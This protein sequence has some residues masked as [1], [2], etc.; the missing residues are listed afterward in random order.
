L[1]RRQ[2]SESPDTLMRAPSIRDVPLEWDV[3][4]LDELEHRRVVATPQRQLVSQAARALRV[5]RQDKDG[6]SQFA[7][8]SGDRVGCGRLGND[9]GGMGATRLALARRGGRVQG[10][11]DGCELVRPGEQRQ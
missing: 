3:L 9:R 6:D 10:V 5:R 2:R 1:D 7:P 4:R 8:G 11:Q